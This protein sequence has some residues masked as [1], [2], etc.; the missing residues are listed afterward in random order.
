MT[1]WIPST[2]SGEVPLDGHCVDPTS[3]SVCPRNQV[4]YMTL[5]GQGVCGCE[6]GFIYD[7][8]VRWSE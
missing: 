8:Q 6:E 7:E 3:A 5:Q 1:S 2:P 4:V